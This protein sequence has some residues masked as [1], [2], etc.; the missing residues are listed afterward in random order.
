MDWIGLLTKGKDLEIPRVVFAK[1][2]QTLYLTTV[3][4]ALNTRNPGLNKLWGAPE[5]TSRLA[6]GEV[7]D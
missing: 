6:A 1:G 2:E 5:D 4:K 7:P 3:K